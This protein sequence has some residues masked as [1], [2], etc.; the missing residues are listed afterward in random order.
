MIYCCHKCSKLED[1][2]SSD[3]PIPYI[4]IEC[5][6]KYADDFIQEEISIACEMDD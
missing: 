6:L 5:F 3:E 1:V 2:R 4:C